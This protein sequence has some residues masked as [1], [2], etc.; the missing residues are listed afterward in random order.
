MT[1]GSVPLA[2]IA[3]WLDE[4]L[5]IAAFD[6][7]GA[8]GLLID[9]PREIALVA[10][11]VTTSYAAIEAA[12]RAGAQLLLTHHPAWER[13]DLEHAERKRGL[14]RE[15]GLA[16]Y[17]AHSSL[18]GA[19][20]ISNSDGLAAAAGVR[21]ERRFLAYCG[22]LAGVVGTCD[23]TFA[24]LVARLRGSLGPEVQAWE[25]APRFGTVA[26]ASGRADAA[27]AIAEAKGLGADTYITGEG[28]MWT[29]LYA[30]ESGVN[31]VFGTHHLTETFGVRSLAALLEQ[32]FGV[33]TTFVEAEADLH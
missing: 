27:A 16:H 33:R 18:D 28:T 12:S 5:R 10:A 29:K 30:R 24:Q 25:N 26:V 32:R 2:D 20:E 7:P 31:L 17:A 13:F 22:G 3:S 23:G 21:V 15:R 1:E 14:L 11:A 9:G 8:N 19:P 6:E 4:R